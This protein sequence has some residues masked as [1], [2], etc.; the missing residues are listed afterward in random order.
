M[1]ALLSV[2]LMFGDYHYDGLQKI[3]YYLG[4]ATYPVYYIANFPSA[5]GDWIYEKLAD[6]KQL[7]QEN[8]SLKSDNLALKSKLQEFTVLERENRR[9]RDFLDSS[10]RKTEWSTLVAELIATD[11]ALFRQRIILNK[12]S[13]HGAHAGQPI[14]GANGVVGQIVTVTPFSAVGMLISDPSH[15]LLAQVARSGVRALTTGTGDPKRL[16]LDY[17]PPDADIREGDILTTSGLDDRYPPGYPI[18]KVTRVAKSVGDNF[19]A[20][21][22]EPFAKVDRNR[23]FLL[24]SREKP[25][26]GAR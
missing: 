12:G 22:V 11:Y 20:I 13:R 3:R 19:A 9:L 7:L 14:L 16:R 26:S 17:V 25:P 18:G 8:R 4:T 1:L 5:A 24:V 23:E 2:V 6:R 15:A 21:T 10:H